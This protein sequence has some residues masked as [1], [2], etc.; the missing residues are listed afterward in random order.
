MKVLL[1]SDLHFHP[2]EPMSVVIN[3]DN[4]RL[5]DAVDFLKSIK[6]YAKENSITHI[7]SLGDFFHTRKKIDVEVY[8]KAYELLR[9]FHDEGFNVYLIAG[10]HDIYYKN[11]AKVTSLRPLSK[12]A[13]VITFP[14]EVQLGSANVVM[15]PYMEQTQML[16]D[17]V[18]K[19]TSH[20]N[21][22]YMLHTEFLGA[23]RSSF[24]NDIAKHGI[25]AEAFPQNAKVFMGHYH[26]YQSLTANIKY[27]GSPL[28][29]STREIHE[30]KFFF[31][32]D[33]ETQELT[34]V[35]SPSPRFAVIEYPSGKVLK[36]HDK[37]MAIADVIKGNYVEVVAHETIK[38]TNEIAKLLPTA[39]NYIVTT[40]VA[41]K[42]NTSNR[43]DADMNL[44][45]INMI[46][47]SDLYLTDHPHEFLSTEF[48]KNVRQKI[49]SI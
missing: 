22:V 32:F 2:H 48:L 34:P 42:T 20:P 49:V 19:Y 31:V 41:V 40:K 36:F 11:T 46:S 17:A 27:L 13:R 1:F 37:Q 45:D 12:Y 23:Q 4:C 15:I 25:T 5:L 38:K 35:H 9:E 33:T 14:T 16:V 43:Q 29:I 6:T 21:L 18:Q 30:D 7:I 39:R 28:Q 26:P 10:N 47:L 3:G 24:G 8:D 44:D